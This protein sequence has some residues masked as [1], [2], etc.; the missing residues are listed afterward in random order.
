VQL[1]SI[2]LL[3]VNAQAL[4]KRLQSKILNKV[5][6]LVLALL[7]GR[8]VS[9]RDALRRLSPKGSLFKSGV[10]TYMVCHA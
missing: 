10:R 3:Y 7:K 2:E 8:R 6:Q 1:G 5:M 4:R 9:L